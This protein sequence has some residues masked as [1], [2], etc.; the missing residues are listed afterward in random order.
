MLVFIADVANATITVLD[1][2]TD[3]GLNVVISETSQGEGHSSPIQHG[4][5]R[6][7]TQWI[8]IVLAAVGI[9]KEVRYFRR[10]LKEPFCAIGLVSLLPEFL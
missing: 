3:T 8:V 9:L 10:F 4:V 7:I 6:P 5:R 1:T 2:T